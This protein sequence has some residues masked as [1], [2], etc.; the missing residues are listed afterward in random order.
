VDNTWSFVGGVDFDS[1]LMEDAFN[2]GASVRYSTSEFS[3]QTLSA[4]R[5]DAALGTCG[6]WTFLPYYIQFVI[7]SSDILEESPS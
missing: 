7:P 2:S 6:Y 5:S 1:G 3:L 4:S